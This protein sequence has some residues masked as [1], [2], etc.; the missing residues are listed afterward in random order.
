MDF[1]AYGPEEKNYFVIVNRVLNHWGA[2]LIIF[3]VY[4]ISVYES[5]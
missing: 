1:I 4:S 2:D 5:A 3:D